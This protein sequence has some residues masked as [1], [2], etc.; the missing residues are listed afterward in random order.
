MRKSYFTLAILTL[1][2]GT[3]QAG[4]N[5][6]VNFNGLTIDLSGFIVV[7]S[8]GSFTPTTFD[9]ALADYSITATNNGIAPFLFTLTNST[10]GGSFGG[11]VNITI[12]A[13]QIVLNAP[14]GATSD[15]G[16]LFLV[17]DATTNGARENLRL[18]DDQL[19]YR[20]P[21]P[22]SFSIFETVPTSFVLATAAPVPEPASWALWGIG[23]AGLG[24]IRRHN[25][26]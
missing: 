24:A 1:L 15:G 25:A 5:Y 6:N 3:A 20:E 9:A 13:T 4:I 8:T 18:Y 2:S 21:N 7:N 22:P 12:S 19:G 14:T 26:V 23:L 11:N 10:W 16:N 17:A